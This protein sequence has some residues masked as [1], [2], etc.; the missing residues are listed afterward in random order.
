V[1]DSC[2]IDE[3]TRVIL[4]QGRARHEHIELQ[5]AHWSRRHTSKTRLFFFF[6]YKKKNKKNQKIK[7]IKIKI[8]EG[9]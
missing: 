2:P 1:V 4:G 9:K 7:K 8:K 6:F 5:L 3:P